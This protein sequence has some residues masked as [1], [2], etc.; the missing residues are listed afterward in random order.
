[1]TTVFFNRLSN[2]PVGINNVN[3]ENADTFAITSLL[4]KLSDFIFS[5]SSRML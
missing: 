2:F 1:M 5:F 4:T 3:P